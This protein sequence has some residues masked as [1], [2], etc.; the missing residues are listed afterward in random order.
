MYEPLCLTALRSLWARVGEGSLWP[1]ALPQ[2]TGPYP[3]PTPK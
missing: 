3:S 1:S 2:L